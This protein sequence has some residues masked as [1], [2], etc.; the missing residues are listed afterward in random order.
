MKTYINIIGII[1]SLHVRRV[2][3]RMRYRYVNTLYK[4]II[5]SF[6]KG[7]GLINVTN[8]TPSFWSAAKKTVSEQVVS[9]A[10]PSWFTLKS[11]GGQ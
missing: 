1:G 3:K 7:R 6:K 8:T 11:A 10:V 4:I 9:R 5:S 2:Q